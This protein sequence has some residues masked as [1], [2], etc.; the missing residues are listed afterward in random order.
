MYVINTL[1]I[2]AR[3]VYIGNMCRKGVL[4]LA[5]SEDKLNLL[6]KIATVKH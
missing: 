5:G 4:L 2:N 6:E 3:A 1:N